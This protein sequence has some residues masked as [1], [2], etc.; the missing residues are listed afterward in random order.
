[1]V[2]CVSRVRRASLALTLLLLA[3]PTLADPL[4]FAWP[5]PAQALV[6][7]EASKAGHS[8]SSSLTLKVSQDAE[9]LTRLDFSDARLLTVDGR[10]L[11]PDEE[12]TFGPLAAAM[13]SL[14]VDK[15]GRVVEVL[16]LEP[17]TE[18]LV[19]ASPEAGRAGLRRALASPRVQAD[20]KAKAAEDWQ[21]WVGL[22]LGR[23]VESG[24]PLVLS[25]TSQVLGTRVQATGTLAHLGPAAG[26]PAGAVRLR[27]ELTAA[28]KDL[29]QAVYG[30]L[31]EAAREAM[32]PLGDLSPEWI[33]AASRTQSVEL[34]ADPGT[35]RPYRVDRETRTLV[36]LRG[37]PAQIQIETKSFR[38][39]WR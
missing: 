9:A 21:A 5:V 11:L 2:T 39:E 22:W 33:E 23:E 30:G 16:G 10:D 14:L 18:G 20:L 13:P 4:R 19:A 29:A 31:A 27:L 26:F 17:L 7:V 28:G 38:F 3:A 34:V 32:R 35:L 8:V 25:T 12:H 1:M 6:T 37:E 15:A 24:R 36:R